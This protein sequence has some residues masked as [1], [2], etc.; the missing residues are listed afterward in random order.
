MRAWVLETNVRIS[1]RAVALTL[2]LGLSCI[3]SLV[4][5]QA[6]IL[7]SFQRRRNKGLVSTVLRMCQFKTNEYTQTTLLGGT[8]EAPARDVLCMN[9]VPLNLL[10]VGCLECNN[11]ASTNVCRLGSRSSVNLFTAIGLI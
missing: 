9:I 7:A 1:E 2:M 8:C 3:V 5:T 11:T 6:L 10:Q 4:H